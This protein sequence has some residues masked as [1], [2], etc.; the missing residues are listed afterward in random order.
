MRFRYVIAVPLLFGV[1]RALAQAGPTPDSIRRLSP[2]AFPSLPVSIRRDLEIRGCLVPQPWDAFFPAGRAGQEPTP[3]NVIRGAFTAAG[4]DEWVVLCSV[5]DTS[6]ILI[7]RVAVGRTARVLDSLLP[8]PDRRWMQGVGGGQWGYSRLV[9]T[10]PLQ[11]IRAWRS[12][13]DGRAIPQPIDHDGIVQVFLDKAAE[14][15]YYVAGRLF[16]RITAD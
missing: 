7:Y 10:L 15:F 2:A 16:R 6:R 14:G 13:I 12:D 1:N 4:V 8:A 11:K 5:S 9:Q 3:R